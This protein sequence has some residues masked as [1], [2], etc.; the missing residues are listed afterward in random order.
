MRKKEIKQ[1]IV[2]AC[3]REGIIKAEAI[4][5]VLATVE[6]ETNG[7]Y[8]PVREAYWLDEAWREQHLDYFPYYGRGYVQLTHEENYAK[9][10][11]LLNVDLVGEP[12]LALER[13][14]AIYIL[15]Q[16]MKQ[17]LFAGKRLSD[18]FNRHGSDFIGARAIINGKDRAKRIARIAQRQ[19][20]I[21][22]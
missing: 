12:D 11:E 16:G 5:Y 2:D 3:I 14:N 18:F 1:E 10:G 17:G 21:Y 22:V 7:T 19:R 9:F 8:L 20:V 15:I 13:E 6:H 4:Q